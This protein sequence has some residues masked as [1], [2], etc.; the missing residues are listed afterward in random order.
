MTL[1]NQSLILDLIE[2]IGETPQPYARVLAAWRTSCPR[3]TIWEDAIDAGFIAHQPAESGPSMV[4]VT[5]AG[6]AFLG[7]HRPLT[8]D[9]QA[10]G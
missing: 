5:S 3:L 1:Q 6:L 10:A 8:R 7:R 4:C 9:P 2:W